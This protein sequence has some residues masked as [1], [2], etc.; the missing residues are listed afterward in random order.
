M[1][2][3]IALELAATAYEKRAAKNPSGTIEV[4]GI[5]VGY[6]AAAKELRR[7]VAWVY[8]ELNTS[9]VQKV[10]RCKNCKNY[11]RY[12]NKKNPRAAVK[13]LCSLD[14]VE[15]GPEFFCAAGEERC[16]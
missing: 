5:R 16:E 12:R 2:L 3:K 8:P 1:N 10:T 14:R 9:E 15:R 7:V 11:K 13:R 6:G 4:F